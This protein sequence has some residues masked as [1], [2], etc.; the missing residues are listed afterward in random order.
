VLREDS[1]DPIQEFRRVNVSLTVDLARQAAAAGVRRFVFASSIGVHGTFTTGSPFSAS[2]LVQPTEP[3]AV[4]KWEAEQALRAIE[5]DSGM[6]LT[7][8]RL[9]LVYGPG[10][11]GNFLRLLR[12]VDSGLP[13]P[14]GSVRNLRSYLGL[15]N[16]CDFVCRCIMHPAARSEVFLL[17][18]GE[19]LSTPA[20]IECLAAA[21]E[22]RARLIAL[23]VP[24]L[25][26]LTAMLGMGG[27]F[28]RLTSSLQVDASHARR[29]LDWSPA[30]P[31][32][33]GL[34]AMAT[35]YV[36]AKG[37]GRG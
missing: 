37:Q 23:P 19:D 2:Q 4:S 9:P 25:D 5:R 1:A 13:L 21:M 10:V 35:W 29:A 11:R 22:R 20:L 14:L 16:L 24:L 31:A 34:A 32:R 7:V 15:D 3:Y 27:E 33:A 17:A 18:D 6:E 8:L 36:G 30:T 12:L 26:K 28:R